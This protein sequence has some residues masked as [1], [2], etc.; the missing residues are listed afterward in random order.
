M[1]LFEIY[2]LF[3]F[4]IEDVKIFICAVFHLRYHAERKNNAPIKDNLIVDSNKYP[5]LSNL[6]FVNMRHFFVVSVE[7]AGEVETR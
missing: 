7:P 3:S 1:A 2:L 6:S 4:N 5:G